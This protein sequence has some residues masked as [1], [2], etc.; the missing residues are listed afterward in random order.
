MA[1]VSRN[2][3]A[4]PLSGHRPTDHAGGR[5]LGAPPT[6]RRV[7]DAATVDGQPRRPEPTG[8]VAGEPNENPVPCSSGGDSFDHCGDRPPTTRHRVVDHDGVTRPEGVP[9]EP[10]HRGLAV[11]AGRMSN[12]DAPTSRS[13][14]VGHSHHSG[15]ASPKRSGSPGNVCRHRPHCRSAGAAE[16][17]RT[18]EAMT[19]SPLRLRR[20]VGPVAV[21]CEGLWQDE[22]PLPVSRGYPC[23]TPIQGVVDHCLLQRRSSRHRGRVSGSTLGPPTSGSPYAR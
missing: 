10:V 18:S 17:A 23:A 13:W 14:Q 11:L 4:R 8:S 7:D 20:N 3:R 6:L 15:N 1:G 2:R 22:A 12:L 5:Q 9:R 21:R 19:P 16:D